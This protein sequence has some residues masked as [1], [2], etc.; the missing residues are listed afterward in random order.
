MRV[1]PEQAPKAA[2]WM[3][4]RRAFGE[5]RTDRMN[6]A[7]ER[8]KTIAIKTDPVHRGSVDHKRR[9]RV[10]LIGD[11]TDSCAALRVKH[12]GKVISVIGG[13]PGWSRSREPRTAL[14]RVP[15]HPGVG[16]GQKYR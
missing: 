3:P 9:R 10:S 1:K 8:A 14:V 16:E 7:R 12:V 11:K 4:T 13:G 6:P 15:D 2:M 5:G